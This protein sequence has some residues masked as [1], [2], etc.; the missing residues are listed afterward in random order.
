MPVPRHAWWRDE[1]DDVATTGTL[2]GDVAGSA[3][4]SILAWQCRAIPNGAA[5]PG[6]YR[7]RAALPLSAC[8]PPRLP[9]WPPGR[10]P[11]LPSAARYERRRAT[12]AGP[13]CIFKRVRL[14]KVLIKC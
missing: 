4:P 1:R 13:R 14:I 10:L 2:T 8:P 3:A 11:R 5:V 12:T 9:S 7:P 6:K